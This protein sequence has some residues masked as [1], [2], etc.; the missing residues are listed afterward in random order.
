LDIEGLALATVMVQSN[1]AKRD[2][3][4]N[5]WNRYTFSDE[6]LPDWFVQDEKKHMKKDAPVPSHLIEEYKNELKV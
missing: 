2:L 6:N 3:M 1:K 5:G 4:D